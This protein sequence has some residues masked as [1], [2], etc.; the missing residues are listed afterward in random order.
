MSKIPTPAT[1]TLPPFGP[2]GIAA[3]AAAWLAL[4]GTKP[5]TGKKPTK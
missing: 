1:S 5:A 4:K 2:I 3:V